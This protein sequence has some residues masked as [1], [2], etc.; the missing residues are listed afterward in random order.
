MSREDAEKNLCLAQLKMG[1]K[2][3]KNMR[4]CGQFTLLPSTII[5]NTQLY[6]YPQVSI[7]NHERYTN[8][9]MMYKVAI[10]KKRKN[11]EKQRGVSF[12]YI[13]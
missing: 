6:Y 3:H 12:C 2:L 10:I 13:D 4:P 1:G 5:L 9:S 7:C 11:D 8:G